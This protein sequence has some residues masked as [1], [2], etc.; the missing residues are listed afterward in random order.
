[1]PTAAVDDLDLLK[2]MR[3]E[4]LCYLQ[5][6]ETN[7]PYIVNLLRVPGMISLIFSEYDYTIITYDQAAN[8]CSLTAAAVKIK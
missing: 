5:L 6:L 3:H 2:D 4:I 7:K 8:R 1:M